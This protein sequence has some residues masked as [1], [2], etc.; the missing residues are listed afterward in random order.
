MCKACGYDAD[1]NRGRSS[2]IVSI[3]SRLLFYGTVLLSVHSSNASKLHSN[4]IF[5][6]RGGLVNAADE[7]TGDY[8]EQF[9]LDYGK[10]DRE[11]HAGSLRGFLKT[12]AITSLPEADP[13]RKWLNAHLEKGHKELK[14][15]VKPFYAA[16]FGTKKDLLPGENPVSLFSPFLIS[17]KTFEIIFTNRRN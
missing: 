4:N 3:L 11:R 5:D 12:G 15:R 16:D 8:Y 10:I 13:F 17:M 1:C 2:S 7:N 14:G 9:E 6:I